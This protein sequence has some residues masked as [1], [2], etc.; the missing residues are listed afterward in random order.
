MSV[1]RPLLDLIQEYVENDLGDAVDRSGAELA[2]ELAERL[3]SRGAKSFK[4]ERG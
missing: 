1:I 2:S 4:G 3:E